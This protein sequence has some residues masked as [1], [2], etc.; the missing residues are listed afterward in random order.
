M[1]HLACHPARIFFSVLGLR[2]CTWAF[3]TC[4]VRASH[5]S[6]FACCGAWTLGRMGS[7]V[8]VHRLGSSAA[9]GIFHMGS[10]PCPLYWQADS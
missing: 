3:S 2:C 6:G 9:C 7:A 10:N 8:V 4:G 1:S 5:C